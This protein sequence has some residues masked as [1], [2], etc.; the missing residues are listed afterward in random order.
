MPDST[1]GGASGAARP[2]SDR[3]ESWKEIAAYLRRDVTT[4]QRWERREGMP[5]HRHLHDKLG[6]VYAFR[7]DLDAWARR[8]SAGAAGGAP[9]EGP[10]EGGQEGDPAGDPGTAPAPEPASRGQAAS[11]HVGTSRPAVLLAAAA[12]AAAA[13]VGAG[14]VWL[15]QRQ[16]ASTRDPLAGA[17]FVP[18]TDFGGVEQAAAISGDGRFVAFLSD[19]AGR[20]DVWLTQVGSGQF[21]D[22]TRGSAPELV[23]PSIRTLGFSPDG[24]LVTFWARGRTGSD[25]PDI[26]IWAVPLLG[27]PP[28]PYLEGAA[29]YAWTR[30]GTRL[31]HH[32]PGPGDPMYVS[33]A[34]RPHEGRRLFSAPAGLHAHF[35]T[36]APDQRFV[37]FV[38]GALPDRLDL[39]RIR[40][41]GSSAPERLTHH[42][43]VV[44]HPVFVDARML[45]YLATDADGSGPWLHALDVEDGVARRVGTGAERYTSL[46]A[47]ADG[48][49]LV[50]TQASPKRTLWRVALGPDRAD[51]AGARPI[52]LTTGTGGSPRLGPGYLVYVSAKG[53]GDGLWKLQDGASTELWSQPGARIAGA[54]AVRRDGRRIAFWTRE[55]G[56]TRLRVVDA[57]GTGGRVVTDAL[58]LSG[59]PA[60]MPDGASLAVGAIVNGAPRLFRVPLEGGAPAP[61]VAEPSADPAWSPA[62]DL[63]A[64]TGADVGTTFPL[65]AVNADG[66]AH[67]MPPLTLTRGERHVAFLPGGRS[68]AVLRGEIRRKH[69]AAVDLASGASR[70][71]IV[72]PPDFDVRDFDVSPDGRELVLEQ[73]QERSDLVLVERPGG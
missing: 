38:Q 50:L 1:P 14:A 53:A 37:Y 12:V 60:W 32:T 71:L 52:P 23:N 68:I 6:S 11:G 47:S 9:G 46:A 70:P 16:A 17:R 42:D 7:S 72:L 18:L 66:S 13:A 63:F 22:L 62:G 15:L 20:V 5:V 49:R 40:A 34:G 56:R 59:A 36:W 51:L 21:L 19:R 35:Q 33:E 48:R 28:R 10:A 30:D 67:R 3:L 27:G 64:F 43:G 26:G 69:L 65:K 25:P 2:A 41:D 4:V 73:V 57:D 24:S 45:L 55:G 58:Q 54:P 31:V 61:L 29:E 8:R 44:S 39:W